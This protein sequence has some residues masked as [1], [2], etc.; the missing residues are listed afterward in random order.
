MRH[1]VSLVEM[2]QNTAR[3]RLP[4]VEFKVRRFSFFSA[5]PSAGKD[6]VATF[7]DEEDDEIEQDSDLVCSVC[8][9]GQSDPPNEIVICDTCNK[10]ACH[11]SSRKG[12]WAVE[13]VASLGSPSSYLNVPWEFLNFLISRNAYF[14]QS[15]AVFGR[16]PFLTLV[17]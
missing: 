17:Y 16:F 3:V 7:E 11:I 10:G 1:Q 5:E 2:W 14:S 4:R 12:H 13:S 6:V 8:N 9:G 15:T